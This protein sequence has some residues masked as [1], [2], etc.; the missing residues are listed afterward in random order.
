MKI[1]LVTV[2]MDKAPDLPRPE[3]LPLPILDPP[4]VDGAK[5]RVDQLLGALLNQKPRRRYSASSYRTM[6]DNLKSYRN[7]RRPKW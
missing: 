1:E 5:D 7:R 4:E 2:G 3:Q 6:R